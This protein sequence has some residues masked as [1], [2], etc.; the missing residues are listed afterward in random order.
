MKTIQEIKADILASNPSRKYQI[1]G[2]EFE[3]TEQE[4][5]EA[6]QKRAEMEFAQIKYLEEQKLKLASKV[7][8]YQKLGLSDAEIVAICNLTEDEAEELLG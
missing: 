5:N 8:G 4:F 3:Q 1:N 2:E 7:T 6:V